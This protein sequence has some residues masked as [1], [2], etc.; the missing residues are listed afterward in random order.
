MALRS[1]KAKARALI[2]GTP[3][4]AYLLWGWKRSRGIHIPFDNV[5]N[6]IYDR[7]AFEIMSRVLA[8]DSNG[9]DVGCHHGEYLRKI[10]ELAP[11]GTHFAFEPIPPMAVALRQQ[12]P[13]V[14]VFEMALS[15]KAGTAEFFYF[16]D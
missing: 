2:K 11:R 4:E 8:E 7:Q 14:D 1:A 10:L 3:V 5:R 16:L 15:D 9:I 12:F 13:S 6:E